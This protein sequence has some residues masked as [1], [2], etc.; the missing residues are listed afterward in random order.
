VANHGNHDAFV[1]LIGGTTAPFVFFSSPSPVSLGAVAVGSSGNP[2]ALTVSN[3]GDALLKISTLT[4]GGTNPGDFS[5]KD[6]CAGTTVVPGGSCTVNITFK[7]AAGG[8]R[9]ATLTVT[10]NNNSVAGSTHLTGQGADFSLSVSPTTN[11]VTA[12]QKATY[13]LTV[14]PWGGFNHQVSLTCSNAPALT[15]CALS[16]ASVTLA[17]G[18]TPVQVS[19]TVA[20]TAPSGTFS[21]RTFPQLPPAGGHLLWLGGIAAGLLAARLRRTY[22]P[23]PVLALTILLAMLWAACGL[24]S[25][26]GPVPAPGTTP[27]NYALSL[28]ATS[29]SLTHSATINLDVH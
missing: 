21:R 12:G 18:T 4:I 27:G 15:N 17:D 24:G 23:A 16:S 29:A 8:T 26:S 2:Q 25:S 7:P 22:K 6:N 20:T 11:T 13:T 28:N 9:T 5:E 14:I 19:V 10:D 3:T 1:T